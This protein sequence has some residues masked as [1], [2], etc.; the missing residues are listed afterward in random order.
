MVKL[1]D[2][3]SAEEAIEEAEREYRRLST[4]QSEWSAFET[5]APSGKRSLN[6][7][8]AQFE[9]LDAARAR[10]TAAEQQ[11]RATKRSFFAGVLDRAEN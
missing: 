10:I 5:V 4:D 1:R 9:R 3:V 8:P 7:L 6:I 2:L 11:L